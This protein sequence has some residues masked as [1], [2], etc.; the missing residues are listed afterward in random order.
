MRVFCPECSEQV[1]LVTLDEA[2]NLSGASSRTIHQ[3]IEE[4]GVH[5]IETADGLVL[6]CPASILRQSTKPR[7]LPDALGR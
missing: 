2:V 5:F 7:R 1:A 4:N 3:Q 6:I